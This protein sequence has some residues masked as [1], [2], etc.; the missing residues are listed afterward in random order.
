MLP[1]ST[2]S[3]RLLVSR[4]LGAAIGC[5]LS[6]ASG[7]ISPN[8]FGE[9]WNVAS[10]NWSL[11]ANWDPN[12]VPNATQAFIGNGGTVTV[13]SAVPNVGA[14]DTDGLIVKGAST[15]NIITGG[16]LTSLGAGNIG[17]GTAGTLNIS[18]G[19]LTFNQHFNL[20]V[21]GGVGVVNQT[22]GTVTVGSQWLA[23]GLGAGAAGSIYDISGGTLNTSAAS[24]E[25]GA[26]R[27]AE[28]KVS[29]TGTVTAGFIGIGLRSGSNGLLTQTGGTVTASEIVVAGGQGTSG[30]F[31]T[32]TKTGGSLTAQNLVVG[33]N[34]GTGLFTLNGGG[35]TLIGNT[36]DNN[37]GL[38]V[39]ARAAGVNPGAGS[40][41]TVDITNGTMTMNGWGEIGRG[42]GTGTLNVTGA[43]SVFA[44]TGGKD[45]A[46]GI[47]G[48]T[49]NLN[50]TAGGTVNMNWWL[51][52]ARG[53]G[54]TGHVVVDGTDSKIIL[55]A[56]QTNIG[57]DGIGTMEIKNGGKF[58]ATEEFSIGRNA[59]SNGN[60]SISGAASTFDLTSHIFVGRNGT[61]VLTQSGGTIDLHGGR[62][63]VADGA[64]SSG[65]VNITGGAFNN[66][67]WFHVGSGSGATG[68]VNVN[69]A[70]PAT[71]LQ[72]S[73]LY[74]GNSGA[75]GTFN[76]NSG[77]LRITNLAEIG[78]N[79][80]HRNTERDWSG[81]HRRGLH[82]WFGGRILQSRWSG[83]RIWSWQC[84]YHEWRT[85]YYQQRMAH[86]RAKR[87]Q[88]RENKSFWCRIHANNA[89]TDRRLEWFR[90]GAADRGR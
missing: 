29:G 70:A 45:F 60:V 55:T 3:S 24:L 40:V 65:T 9:N 61:G 50:V 18:D 31:G 85:A 73:R 72:T 64:N 90:G 15:L 80:G 27:A 42:Q 44:A 68:T 46:V 32:Y 87:W 52:V 88:S 10:G 11:P 86:P 7:L 6:L 28:L 49:G 59:G 20:G 22:G 74:V 19:S 48:G 82:R 16:S 38:F 33:Q 51:N 21:N 1:H 58:S 63:Q 77:K 41:G 57:E 25:V 36:S 89:W 13:D 78:R 54:S 56:G 71:I 69:Y 26:D 66:S 2:F 5:G 75:T 43:S 35:T 23:I 14:V 17:D 84:E 39:G 8:A 12:T 79:G 37:H 83:W 62:V 76:V 53:G 47:D 81:Q 67:E 4:W 34:G 30:Q